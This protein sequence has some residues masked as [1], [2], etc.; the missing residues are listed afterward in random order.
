MKGDTI[1]SAIEILRDQETRREVFRLTDGGTPDRPWPAITITRRAPATTIANG[2]YE[3]EI[4]ASRPLPLNAVR[5][6]SVRGSL[7]S[8]RWPS[9]REPTAV[10]DRWRIDDEWWR[11]EAVARLYY[12]V[13]LASGHRAVLYKDII[14]GEWYKQDY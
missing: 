6:G 7:G 11:R 9:G 3:I 13:R 10:E 8:F 1:P 12:S 4:D 14:S 2:V 5:C